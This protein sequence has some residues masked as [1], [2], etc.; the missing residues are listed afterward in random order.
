MVYALKPHEQLADDYYTKMKAMS[1]LA[2]PQPTMNILQGKLPPLENKKYKP[3]RFSKPLDFPVLEPVSQP[4]RVSEMPKTLSAQD[5]QMHP[6][7]VFFDF[8]SGQEQ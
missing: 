7:I 6:L 2:D 1:S 4:L 3:L 8:L 5:S